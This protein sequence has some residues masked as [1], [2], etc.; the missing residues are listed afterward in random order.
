MPNEKRHAKLT[1]SS[2]AT[3]RNKSR[4]ASIAAWFSF[5]SFRM[6]VSEFSTSKAKPFDRAV[7]I[8]L[9]G[10]GGG[11]G[12]STTALPAFFLRGVVTTVVAAVAEGGGGGGRA[13]EE[14]AAAAVTLRGDPA[15]G[16]PGGGG[17]GEEVLEEGVDGK[18]ATV[19]L[20]IVLLLLVLVAVVLGVVVLAGAAGN[21]DGEATAALAIGVD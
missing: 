4:N 20:E 13:D 10:V 5:I 3:G 2:L 16:G 18:A 19:V 15:G 9:F 1:T 8:T 7:D 12:V 17:L 21:G 14:L 11:L 6:Y